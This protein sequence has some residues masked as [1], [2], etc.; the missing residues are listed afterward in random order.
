MREKIIESF[1]MSGKKLTDENLGKVNWDCE[2]DVI[3]LIQLIEYMDVFDNIESERILGNMDCVKVKKILQQSFKMKRMDPNY[4]GSI[5]SNTMITCGLVPK[6]PLLKHGPDSS[7]GAEAKKGTVDKKGKLA[8]N[9]VL[10]DCTFK[11]LE[12]SLKDN[13]KFIF[14][15]SDRDGNP[16]LTVSFIYNDCSHINAI[17]KLETTSNPR[18]TIILNP[19]DFDNF[20]IENIHNF[21]K[22]NFVTPV[23]FR[24]QIR[25]RYLDTQ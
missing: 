8:I 1:I 11:F 18:N 24:S 9:L 10:Q 15:G 22:I 14:T 21:E 13:K 19:G 20:E 12:N 25:Q 2:E 5:E 6:H 4:S 23:Y 16:I 3:G 17:N 7:T